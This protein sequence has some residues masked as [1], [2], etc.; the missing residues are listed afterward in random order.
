MVIDNGVVIGI[1]IEDLQIFM[2]VRRHKDA[3]VVLVQFA[4]F[5]YF[6]FAKCALSYSRPMFELFAEQS[7]Y[8]HSLLLYSAPD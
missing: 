3:S 7:C 6:N 5:H 8:F 2:E 1:A 4:L